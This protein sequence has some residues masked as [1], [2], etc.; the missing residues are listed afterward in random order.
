MAK[1]FNNAYFIAFLFLLL[2]L[3]P[4]TTSPNDSDL[5]MCINYR[6][7]S[8]NR[9][10]KDRRNEQNLFSPW[11]EAVTISFITILVSQV[12]SP[13]TRLIR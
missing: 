2:R 13:F 8:S 7:E 12:F 10:L 9:I 4:L 6:R 5:F 11:Y 3:F 1:H